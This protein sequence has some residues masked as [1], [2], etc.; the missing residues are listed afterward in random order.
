[1]D[2]L[3]EVLRWVRVEPATEM[4]ASAMAEAQYMGL[5][6]FRSGQS[7]LFFGRENCLRELLR[8]PEL[9]GDGARA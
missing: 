5:A 8:R 6:P 4:G 2:P 3:H 1:M 7:D 9:T